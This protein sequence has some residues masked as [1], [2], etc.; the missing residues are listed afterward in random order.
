MHRRQPAVARM[1]FDLLEKLRRGGGPI[2]IRP[3]QEACSGRRREGHRYGQLR[4][5]SPANARIGLSPGEVKHELAI[6]VRLD[7]GGRCGRESLLIGERD[8]RRIPSRAR[9]Y[10]VRV[11]ESCEELMSQERVA[12]RLSMRAPEPVPL[13]R[14]E[15]VNAVNYT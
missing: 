6:G 3:N 1:R 9:S 2:Q 4:V 8:V 10:T 7:E 14:V 12:V 11:L 13:P 5:V 15:L